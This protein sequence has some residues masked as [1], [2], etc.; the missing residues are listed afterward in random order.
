MN[1]LNK[2]IFKYTLLALAAI[3]IGVLLLVFYYDKQA[4]ENEFKQDV[5]WLTNAVLMSSREPLWNLDEK[6]LKENL[7]SF[8]SVE[9]IGRLM[10]QEDLDY[11]N[12]DVGETPPKNLLLR[13]TKPILYGSNYLGELTIYFTKKTLHSNTL[14]NLYNLIGQIVLLFLL[15]VGLITFISRKYAEPLKNLAKTIKKFDIRDP[16]TYTYIWENTDVEE[17]QHVIRSYKEMAEEITAN[18]QELEATNEALKEINDKLEKKSFENEQ[19][20]EKLTKIIEISSKFDETTNMDNRYFMK[21]LFQNAFQI[22]PEADYGTV[23]IYNDKGVL[24]IDSVGH[25][26]GLL[27]KTRIPKEIFIKGINKVGIDRNLLEFTNNKISGI[28]EK[29]KRDLELIKQ[30]SKDYKE[31][32]YFELSIGNVP[33]GG[34]SLDIASESDKSF[35]NE[36]LESMKAFRYLATAFY[37]IQRYSEMKEAFTREII[38]SIVKMLE[39]HD[40]YTKGHSENVANLSFALSQELKLNPADCKQAYW[41]GLVHDLGKI[42]IPDAILNKSSKLTHDEFEVIKQH[43]VWGYETLKNSKR[44]KNI[45]KLVLHHHERWDGFGYPNGL[46]GKEIPEISRIITIVDAWDAMSSKR[47]YRK[48][49]DFETALNEIKD[50][51]GKQFDPDFVEPFIHMMM[52]NREKISENG[53]FNNSSPLYE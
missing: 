16:S 40:N 27:K 44:L 52:K 13:V 19:L 8:L 28:S 7:D 12:I 38:I 6:V 25:D 39:I 32:L 46:S 45:A 9:T 34:I 36:A 29:E 35:S 42:L 2:K 50:N 31:T 49:L 20:A 17:I 41:A 18:Y 53:K 11:L 47:S 1:K 48:P 30:A 21:M 5:E 51:A 24:F 23:Y 15:V 14:K 43:P 33:E 3:F 22:I 10:V 26:L 37:K 4:L